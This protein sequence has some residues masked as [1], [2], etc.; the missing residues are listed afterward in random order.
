MIKLEGIIYKAFENFIVFRGYAPI[1]ILSK[2]S[3]RPEAYQR[4][5]DETHKRDIIKFLGKKDYSYFPELVL[6]YRGADLT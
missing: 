3:K 2:V 4:T 6:A 5:A 1:G